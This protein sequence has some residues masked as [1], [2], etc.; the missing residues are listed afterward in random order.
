M[1]LDEVLADAPLLYWRLNEATPGTGAAADASGNGRNGAYVA[2]PVSVPGLLSNDPNNA[3]D[4]NGSSQWVNVAYNPFQQAAQRTFECWCRRRTV[5][6]ADTI[7]GS[8]G[9]SNTHVVIA[10]FN[11]TSGFSFYSSNSDSSLQTWTGAF[12]AASILHTVLTWDGATKTAEL[13]VDGI[14]LGAKVLTFDFGT[15]VSNVTLGKRGSAQDPFDGAL[16]EF[17]VYNGILS[18]TRISAHFAAGYVPPLTWHGR[19]VV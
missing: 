6:T 9:T 4:F 7:F 18:P 3:V 8:I 10:R 12:P 13:W 15:G 14:S 2:S 5:A 16:D 17:A 1:Y 11:V 19:G